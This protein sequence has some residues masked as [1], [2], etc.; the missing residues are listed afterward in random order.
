MEKSIAIKEF[1][2]TYKGGYLGYQNINNFGNISHLNLNGTS[3]DEGE[4]I[5]NRID[6]LENKIKDYLSYIPENMTYSTLPVLRFKYPNGEYKT[7]TI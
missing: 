3:S 1:K 7:I 2:K 4:S 6:L 5:S